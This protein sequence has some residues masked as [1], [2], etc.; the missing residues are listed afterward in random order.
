MK[1]TARATRSGRWWSVEV[2]EIDGLHTQVRRLDQVEEM[3]RDAAA[4]LEDLA[5][6]DVEVTVVPVVADLASV[7]LDELAAERADL[8]RLRAAHTGHLVAAVAELA[9]RGL[10]LRETAL[11]LGISHQRVAQLRGP[12]VRDASAADAHT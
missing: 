10:T 4:L 1:V 8:Q 6:D 5:P 3:V 11:V 12:A 7:S 2:P 9:G